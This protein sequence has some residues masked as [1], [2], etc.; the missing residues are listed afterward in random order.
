MKKIF[1][2]M[3]IT[4]LLITHAKAGINIY[5]GYSL[6][7][8]TDFKLGNITGADS[9]GGSLGLGA[10]Y[11]DKINEKIGF[12]LGATYFLDRTFTSYTVSTFPGT[13]FIYADPKPKLSGIVLHANAKY[14]I[15]QDLYALGGLNYLIP[16]TSNLSAGT[17]VGG[18]LGFQFGAGYNL[19]KTFAVEG[20]YRILNTD[21]KSS[22]VIAD[23]YSLNGLEINLKYS[24]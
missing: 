3:L 10:E 14:L 6:A 19:S 21:S 11:S 15:T 13:T 12:A 5:G 7:D 20:L 4:A 9:V 22:G 24:L 23:T 8:K 17:T 2:A 1:M 18:K 16:Q